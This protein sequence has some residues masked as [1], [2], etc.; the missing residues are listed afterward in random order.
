M[1]SLHVKVLCLLLLLLQF[2]VLRLLFSEVEFDIIW[3]TL[4]NTGKMLNWLNC[5]SI[6]F[7]IV[8]KWLWLTEAHAYYCSSTY[9][10][11]HSKPSIK[12]ACDFFQTGQWL[13]FYER[14]ILGHLTNFQV[15]YRFYWRNW[16]SFN[17]FLI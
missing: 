7:R 6:D 1:G 3:K 10:F 9:D 14:T 2:W 5:A 16:F 13:N 8:S 15:F 12:N 17:T 4:K 11:S